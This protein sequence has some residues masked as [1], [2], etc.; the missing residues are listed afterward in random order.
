MG[1]APFPRAEL[2][3]PPLLLGLQCMAQLCSSS[4]EHFLGLCHPG[5]SAQGHRA[6]ALPAAGRGQCTDILI[7]LQSQVK[8]S[9]DLGRVDGDSQVR[10]CQVWMVRSQILCALRKALCFTHHISA[11]STPDFS[12]GLGKPELLNL[13]CRHS[14]PCKWGLVPLG[15]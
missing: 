10:I 13:K 7:C 9:A 6:L 14:D 15:L 5:V 2:F 1:V 8:A 4:P 3:I 12:R 11:G